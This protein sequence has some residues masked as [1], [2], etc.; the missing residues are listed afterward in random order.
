M[1]FSLSSRHNWDD[2]IASGGLRLAL[3]FLERIRR[4]LGA[5]GRPFLVLVLHR[6][7]TVPTQ[8]DS[9][10]PCDGASADRTGWILGLWCVAHGLDAIGTTPITKAVARLLT[11]QPMGEKIKFV[12]RIVAAC[13]LRIKDS[14]RISL[15]FAPILPSLAA[16]L[17]GR[18]AAP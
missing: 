15:F 14:F 8:G 18:L 11:R 7:P 2:A 16:L 6:S 10:P 12:Y 17:G 5:E 13:E 9:I 1:C 4:I 3:Q